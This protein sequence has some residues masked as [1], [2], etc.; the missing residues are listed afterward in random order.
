MDMVLMFS[1]YPFLLEW[2]VAVNPLEPWNISNSIIKKPLDPLSFFL[3]HTC[4]HQ[5]SSEKVFRCLNLVFTAHDFGTVEL[6]RV[7]FG[8]E[9]HQQSYSEGRKSSGTRAPLCSEQQR[10]ARNTCR[11][12]VAL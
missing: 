8:L 12:T 6:P 1:K 10:W 9:S 3:N 7:V 5:P 4:Q 11:L 2:G